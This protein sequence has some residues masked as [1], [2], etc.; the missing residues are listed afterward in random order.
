MV[1]VGMPLYNARRYL[2]SALDAI[3]AQEFG[4]FELVI[5]DNASTDETEAICREYATRDKRIRYFRNDT[6]LGVAQNFNSVFTRGTGKYFMW[7]AYDDHWAPSFIRRCVEALEQNPDA[8]VARSW[9]RL[10]DANG[11]AIEGRLSYL[12]GHHS[13]RER[14]IGA[15]YHAGVLAIYGVIRRSALERTRLLEN[16]LHADVVLMAELALQGR[17]LTIPEPLS[18][19]RTVRN[20]EPSFLNEPRTDLKYVDAPRA[21]PLIYAQRCAALIELALRAPLPLETRALLIGDVLR[22]YL[23]DFALMTQGGMLTRKLLGTDGFER[24]R[25]FA[26]GQE[27]YRRLRRY[28]EEGR[29][30]FE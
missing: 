7:A 13:L 21:L 8:V 10:F 30:R 16:N 5:S 20:W 9:T 29:Q 15:L 11:D 26:R 24:V 12:D 1:T 17:F 6:N 14:F 3:A 27:W 4:D 22:W 25:N 18:S 28:P 19:Y 2:R 23:V